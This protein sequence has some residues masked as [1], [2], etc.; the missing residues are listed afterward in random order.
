MLFGHQET[1]TERMM[2]MA[3]ERASDLASAMPSVD[4]DDVEAARA[5]GWASL[6]IGAT[7]LAAPHFVEDL[8]GLDRD[9]DRQ[10]AIRA[11]GVRELAHGLSILAEDEPNHKLAT[12]VWARVAGDVLDTVCLGRA[13]MQTK[14]PGRFAAVSAM[15]MAIG[16]ADLWC[17]TRLS[18]DA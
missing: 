11:L 9:A 5:L 14:N 1:R 3:R 10:G 18:S 2:N 15:V 7:E 12:S 16:V 17:A 13:A 8:L 6:A 4:I